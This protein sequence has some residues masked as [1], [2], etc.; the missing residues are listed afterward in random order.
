MTVVFLE[1]S[2]PWSQYCRDMKSPPSFYLLCVHTRDQ[3]QHDDQ[4][5]TVFCFLYEAL[6]LALSRRAD[7]PMPSR[8][9]AAR[10]PLVAL[11][12]LLCGNA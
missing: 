3:L 2:T 4:T 1:P 10:T 11:P 9:I 5:C 12:L 8:A 6:T 7:A